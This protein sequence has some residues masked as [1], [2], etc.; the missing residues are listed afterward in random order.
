MYL[1]RFFAVITLTAAVIS[2]CVY[3]LEVQQ[4]NVITQGQ[5]AQLKPE[6]TKQSVLYLLGTPMV[7]D[8][9][10]ADRWDYIFILNSDERVDRSYRVTI[11][12]NEVGTLDRF[13]TV[14]E[15]PLEHYIDAEADKKS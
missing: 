12:F 5:V 1:Q 9:F 6:M 3:H 7:T 11:Y 8:P 4:G 2:G 13:E 14:G 10:H 15:L